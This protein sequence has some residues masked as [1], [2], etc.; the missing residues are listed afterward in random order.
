MDIFR[1]WLIP[2]LW[3]VRHYR[4]KDHKN[5]PASLHS[6]KFKITNQKAYRSQKK[7]VPQRFWRQN[8]FFL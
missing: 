7:I 2:D 4:R 6:L 8:Y 5:A 1:I 3:R